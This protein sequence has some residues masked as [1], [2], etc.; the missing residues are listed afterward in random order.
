[1]STITCKNTRLMS[2][3]NLIML[4]NG[5]YVVG[6]QDICQLAQNN[7]ALWL[8]CTSVVCEKII[9]LYRDT[10]AIFTKLSQ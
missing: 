2:W 10:I 3:Y 1:M 7:A 9:P 4:H 8:S 6:G 5:T